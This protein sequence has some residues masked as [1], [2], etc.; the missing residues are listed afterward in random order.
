MSENYNNSNRIRSK[1]YFRKLL[2]VLMFVQIL[3]AYAT[4]FPGS[5]PSFIAAEFLGSFSPEQQNSI[6]AFA[7]SIVSI[8]MYFLFFTQYLSDKLGR[9]KTLAIT[10]F[11]MGFASLGMFLSVNYIMYQSFVFILYFFFS[12]DIWVIIINEESESKK[13]AYYSNIIPLVGLAGPVMMVISRF[14]FATGGNAFWRGIAIIPITLGFIITL[15]V[16]LTL[17]E[18]S[19]YED[20][21]SSGE[22]SSRTFFE[23]L[24]SIFHTDEKKS[25]II[26]LIISF[27]FGFSNLF[28]TLFEKYIYDVGTINQ[29][30]VTYLFLL[31][32]FTVMAAYLINGLLADRIGRKPLLYLWSCLLPISVLIWVIGALQPNAV[33]YVFIGY[34]L[35]H[36]SYWGLW[37]IIRLTTLELVPTDRRGTG[38]GFR[39]LINS[40][41]ATIGLLLSSFI[42]LIVGLGT[43]FIIF[44]LFNVIM[45]PLSAFLVKETKGVD[46]KDIK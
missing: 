26:M 4:I 17:K 42:I 9:K 43:T 25:Y 32:I 35:S 38:V 20:M 7:G 29:T 14:I 10:V 18:T 5:I 40:I 23:D 34:P 44:V 21:K 45:I 39:A 8:G 28:I 11:G 15:V 31:T 1:S 46:L 3:D 41:G 19:K 13:R 30:L 36:V 2:I 37:G 6:M 12:S 16:M 22:F 27:L 33:L 24:K